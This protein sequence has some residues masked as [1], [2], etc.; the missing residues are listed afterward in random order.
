MIRVVY[1]GMRTRH[2]WLCAVVA[3]FVLPSVA[4][5]QDAEFDAYLAEQIESIGVPGAVVGVFKDGE[6]IYHRAFGF[7]NVG[8]DTPMEED[9]AFEIGSVSKQFVAIALLTFVVDGKLALDDTLGKALPSAPEAW[10]SVTIEQLLRHVSGVP[11]YE[12][13]AGYDFYNEER[14]PQEIFD[15]AL[16]RKPAFEP[17]DRFSYSN[18]GYVLLS[19]I[20]ERSAG[21]P[22]SDVLEERIFRPLG[23]KSTYAAKRPAGVTPAT[24]YH[25]R[26]GTRKEQPPIAWSSTLAAGGIVSTIKDMQKWDEALY[27]EKVLPKVTLAKV[28]SL[29]KLNDGTEFNYGFGWSMSA[30]RDEPTQQHSGQTNGFT[31]YFIRFPQHHFSVMFWTNTYGGH[32]RS[33]ARETAIHFLPKL[34]YKSLA[35]PNDDDPDRT[36][37]HERAL[38][39]AILAEGDL[40]LLAEGIREFAEE[41]RFKPLRDPLAPAVRSTKSFEF[42]RLSERTSANGSVV[43]QY[44]YR[45]TYE[46]G[47][48]FWTMTF[49]NGKLSGLNWERE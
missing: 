15:E 28:W 10:H 36:R 40:D 7:A 19:L 47:V 12:A 38:R 33:L 31:C 1:R 9:L 46:N 27:T 44:L 17:G 22:V 20:V 16:K 18:T 2:S 32:I 23:M 30:L 24:G 11:D 49:I 3:G 21:K 6:I 26:T 41:D 4:S 34:S 35:I 37:L 25:S 42:V 43:H 48:Y 8:V 14:A 45:H 13:I 29:A 39:Q 5:A